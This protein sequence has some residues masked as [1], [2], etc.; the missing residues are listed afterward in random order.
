MR[1]AALQSYSRRVMSDRQSVS[2]RSGCRCSRGRRQ[3]CVDWTHMRDTR[4]RNEIWTGRD[5]RLVAVCD[6]TQGCLGGPE[7]VSL[8]LGRTVRVLSCFYAYTEVNPGRWRLLKV[9]L[10]GGLLE[11]SDNRECPVEVSVA[12]TYARPVDGW[13]LLP[14]YATRLATP[15][16]EMTS[17][18][19]F[20]HHWH[21]SFS[22]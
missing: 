13:L 19:I 22:S 21:P 8:E 12:A 10:V 2:R 1:Y 16:R 6:D 17:S 15:S 5:W 20:N 3:V 7:R 11:T 4:G 18:T 14:S 9:C